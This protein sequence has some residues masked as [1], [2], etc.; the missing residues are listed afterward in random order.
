MGKSLSKIILRGDS[1]YILSGDGLYV[2]DLKQETMGYLYPS[3]R[4]THRAG[5]SFLIDSKD[6]IW[7]AQHDQL[8]RINM[9]MPEEKYIYKY[10]ER[11]LG[12][13]QVLNIVEYTDGTLY[14]GTYGAGLYVFNPAE[15]SFKQCSIFDIRYCYNLS[16]IQ[17]DYLAVSCEKGLLVYHPKTQ[18]MKMIDA[19]N[20][21]HLS[22]INDGCGLLSCS[23]G[24]V[25]V[26]GT[27]GMAS[28]MSHSLFNP[29][30]RYNL[31][32]SS[33]FVNDKLVSCETSDRILETALPFAD[34]INLEYNENN[35]SISVASNSYIDNANRKIYEYWLEGFS[36][37]WNTIYNNTI[38]YTNLNPGKYKLIVREKQQSY[39]MRCIPLRWLLLYILLGGL[40]GWLIWFT[41]VWLLQSLIH[42]CGTGV[43]ECSYVLRWRKRS[44]RKKRT[45]NLYRQNFSF[46]P[47]YLTNSV[48]L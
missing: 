42:C 12:K 4:E 37:E 47:I 6:Y 40:H 29:S 31:Y 2:K 1:L 11:G 7:I 16:V 48:L 5:S 35:I 10:N 14:F 27:S 3:I 41:F 32:F 9:K 13:F 17:G 19:E 26:G 25:F 33:L 44:L 20:Q 23:D 8:V 43:P 15:N 28:F 24:E 21:L 18:E 34:Q 39:L 38:V 46:L 30:P 22:A 36:N 45:K